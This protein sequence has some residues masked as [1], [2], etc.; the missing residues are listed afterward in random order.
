M[1]STRETFIEH[2][3]LSST[4]VEKLL[5][6]TLT[7]CINSVELQQQIDSLDSNL[8]KETLPT[9]R[10]VLAQQLPPFYNWLKY[11]LGVE[12]VPDSPEHTTKWV[13]GFLNNQESLNRL[14]DLHRPVQN[15]A[16][17]LGIPPLVGLFD[18]V[19]DTQ[20][21]REWQKAIASLCLVLVVAS[22]E[23]TRTTSA[24]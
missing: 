19:E 24:A 15:Q 12:R 3:D 7:E 4:E 18:G 6:K 10:S 23:E 11:E 17:E 16:L 8:L 21:R 9:V 1:Q 2:L 20:I 14:V 22:R 5:S 13:V